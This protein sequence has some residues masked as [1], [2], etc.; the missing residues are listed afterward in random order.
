M[1][2][3]SAVAL[4]RV[5]SVKAILG[6]PTYVAVDGGMADNMRPVAYGAAYTAVLADR[7][8]E[9]PDLDVAI[10][11]RYC[12][13]GDIL[14]QRVRLPEP[15]IGDLVAVPTAG[16]YQMAM[17]SNYN[18]APRPAVVVVRDGTP[19]LVRRRET[20]A[21]LLKSELF[22]DRMRSEAS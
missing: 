15:R 2:A 19:L 21:E 14:I 10:A 16:A 18:L 4:Y 8:R 9:L 11:G 17:A 7:A 13:S 1:V 6:G 3:T 22:G 5:G 12:E 20:Y